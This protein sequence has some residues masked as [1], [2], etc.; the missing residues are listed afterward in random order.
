MTEREITSKRVSDTWSDYEF[1]RVSLF[2]FARQWP[3][4]GKLQITQGAQFVH[5]LA[6]ISVYSL[7]TYFFIAA[8]N[9]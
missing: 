1:E 5:I 8:N 9:S 3:E 4:V 7:P 2:G 6:V